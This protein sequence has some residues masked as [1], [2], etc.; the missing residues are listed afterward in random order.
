MKKL[1]AAASALLLVILPALAQ[2]MPIQLGPK[3]GQLLVFNRSGTMF[4]EVTE[5]DGQLHLQLLDAEK[6]PVP[7]DQHS[8]EVWGGE[9]MHP[10][11][12]PVEQKEGRFVAPIPVGDDIWFMFKMKPNPGSKPYR[13]RLHYNTAACPECGKPMWLCEC[14]AK[15]NPA[16]EP[17]K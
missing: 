10:V 9:R 11:E 5:Q 2:D 13:A 8:C 7:L 16:A 6:K 15:K 1:F 4:G 14:A 17:P 3:G 12:L